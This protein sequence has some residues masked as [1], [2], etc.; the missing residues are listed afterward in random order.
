MKILLIGLGRIG[1]RHA[2]SLVN[3]G[4]AELHLV[5]PVNIDSKIDILLNHI[6]V[7]ANVHIYSDLTEFLKKE[8]TVDIAIIATTSETRFELLSQCL[9]AGI[10][11]KYLLEKLLAPDLRY[12]EKYKAIKDSVAADIYVNCPQRTYPFYRNLLAKNEEIISARYAG[13]KYIGLGSNV[14]HYVDLIESMTGKK[15]ITGSGAK[16]HSI[17]G[18]KR[19]EYMEYLGE[20]ELTIGEIQ[21]SF[22]AFDQET[23]LANF[24]IETNLHKYHIDELENK[25]YRNGKLFFEK[26]IKNQSDITYFLCQEIILGQ[27]TLPSLKQSIR[28]HKIVLNVLQDRHVELAD[29]TMPF[30]V[31]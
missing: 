5:D 19:P 8:L 30:K 25:A 7:K 9:D 1:F 10:S 22:A 18:S 17:I 11:G 2:Q 4:A 24:Y 26:C 16:L 27:S 15:I 20:I 28:Q 14:I 31:S 3:E 21:F 29:K 23:P 13:F 12:L 6:E